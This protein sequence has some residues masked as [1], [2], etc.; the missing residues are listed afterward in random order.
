VDSSAGLKLPE[1]A[2]LSFSYTTAVVKP[3]EHRAAGLTWIVDC[4]T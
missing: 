1:L 4:E 2:L 3:Q